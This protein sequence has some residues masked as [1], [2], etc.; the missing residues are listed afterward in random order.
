MDRRTPIPSLKGNHA[1][2]LFASVLGEGATASPCC[3]GGAGEVD[4]E[5]VLREGIPSLAASSLEVDCSQLARH[6]AYAG[7]GCWQVS[8]RATGILL[9]PGESAL[10]GQDG[11]ERQSIRSF[12]SVKRIIIARVSAFATSGLRSVLVGRGECWESS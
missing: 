7:N 9:S 12:W 2:S 3:F 5:T 6:A 1:H 10:C 11:L 8:L 4:R